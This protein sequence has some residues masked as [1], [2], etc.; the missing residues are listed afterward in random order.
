MGAALAAL[1]PWLDRNQDQG[2]GAL[3]LIL[4]PELVS[5]NPRGS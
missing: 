3:P 1:Q 2:V 4:A 5:A